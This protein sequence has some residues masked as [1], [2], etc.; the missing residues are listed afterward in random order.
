MR[1]PGTLA[2]LT[3]ALAAVVA[4]A[5]E[6]A[7]DKRDLAFTLGIVPAGIAADIDPGEEACQVPL[8]AEERFRAVSFVAVAPGPSRG[9]AAVRVRE[10]PGGRTLASGRGGGYVGRSQP[11]V[12]LDREVPAEARIEVCVRN[13]GRRNLV[14]YGRGAGAKLASGVEVDGHSRGTDLTLVFLRGEQRSA[15]SLVP[16]MFH[17]AA[18][19]RPRWVGAWTFWVLLA[20]VLCGVPALLAAALRS[21]ET[22]ESVQGDVDLQPATHAGAAPGGAPLPRP[23]APR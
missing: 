8:V 13:T 14:L 5:V 17:R 7:A 4:L 16:A 3:I 18:L 2:F 10:V 1:R 22:Q 23:R 12:R 20:L 11:N 19:F 15:L 21:A 9:S 6:A